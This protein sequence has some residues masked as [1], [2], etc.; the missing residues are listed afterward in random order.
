V[1]SVHVY[2]GLALDRA[3]VRFDDLWF[4]G[5]RR[6]VQPPFHTVALLAER[7]VRARV[8]RLQSTLRYACNLVRG[9]R[10]GIQPPDLVIG[11][12][13]PD[14]AAARLGVGHG[15]AAYAPQAPS[16]MPRVGGDA[17]SGSCRQAPRFRQS[18]SPRDVLGSSGPARRACPGGSAC[19]D[20]AACA[21]LTGLPVDVQEFAGTDRLLRRW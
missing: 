4:A 7:G 11:D 3:D 17:R 15:T 13:D 2:E 14:C 9:V 6:P 18:G 19:T 20:Y 1:F 10:T 8:P 12:D 5:L 16:G 21:A